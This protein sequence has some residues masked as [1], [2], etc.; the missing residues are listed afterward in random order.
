MITP[1]VLERVKCLVYTASALILKTANCLQCVK[2]GYLHK[3]LTGCF[4]TDRQRERERE[5]ERE[6]VHWRCGSNCMFKSNLL[7]LD[8]EYFVQRVRQVGKVSWNED[9]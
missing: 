5:R 7:Q 9:N 8:S 2:K 1:Y 6:R 3:V 4:I